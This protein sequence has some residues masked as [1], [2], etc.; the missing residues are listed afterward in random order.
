MI[1][2][3]NFLANVCKIVVQISRPLKNKELYYGHSSVWW[4]KL[5]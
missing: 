3:V 1:N 4:Q 5:S 2:F